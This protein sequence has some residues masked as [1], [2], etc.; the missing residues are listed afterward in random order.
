MDHWRALLPGRFLEV[1]YEDI[2]ADMEKQARALLSYCDL[3]WEDACLA[4]HKTKRSVRT[5]SVLQVRQPIYTSSVQR[6][7]RVEKYLAPL[8]DALGEYAPK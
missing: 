5:A 7:R 2:V 3:P 6:W 8:I 4:F 1:Q